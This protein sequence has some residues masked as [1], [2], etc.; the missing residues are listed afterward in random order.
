[1]IKKM[2][3]VL[4]SLF[5]MSTSAIAAPFLICD[6]PPDEE[7]VF[8]YVLLIDGGMV[9]IETPAPL[10][11]DLGG[12][13]DGVHDF[14]VRAENVEGLSGP[15]FFSFTKGLPSVPTEFR[16]ISDKTYKQGVKLWESL[17]QDYK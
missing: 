15:A 13:T 14:E 10:H 3:I 6:D 17:K 16:V 9:A 8:R 11:Y 1:M 5:L 12:M 4:V 7:R 2:M